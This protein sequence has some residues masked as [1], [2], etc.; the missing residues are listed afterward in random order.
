M[1][2]HLRLS[3][4]YAKVLQITFGFLIV[5]ASACFAQDS[6][7]Y[8][9]LDINKPLSNTSWVSDVTA[10]GFRAGYRAFINDRFSAGLDIS[11]A[12]FD[13]YKPT[14]TRQT[15]AGAITTD[16]FNYI[17][18]YSATASVQYNF[19]DPRENRLVPYVGIGL[20]A[21]RNEYTLYYNRYRDAENAWGFLARPEAGVLV[22]LNARGTV[23]AMAAV[24]YDF[25][26]NK[27][28]NFNYDSFSSV[29]FQIGLAFFNR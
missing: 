6:Y 13:E 5:S 18:N 8:V 21:N 27:S 3:S 11:N 23:G 4:L 15:S 26:T 7:F 1:R 20:G 19:R 16:Y 9:N 12:T 24:H 10:R 14:E 29:G 25:S 22:K 28:E 2:V 17:Y